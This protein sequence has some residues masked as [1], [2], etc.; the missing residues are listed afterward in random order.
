VSWKEFLRRFGWLAVVAFALT[1]LGPMTSGLQSVWKAAGVA[2][3]LCH[4]R[5]DPWLRA[6]V[7]AAALGLVIAIANRLLPIA[8]SGD[9]DVSEAISPKA[10]TVI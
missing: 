8:F 10:A 9:D 6:L 4:L 1:Q 5:P 2:L 7:C 3:T